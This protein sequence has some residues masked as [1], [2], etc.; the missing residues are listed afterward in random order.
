METE[1]T[2][3]ARWKELLVGRIGENCFHVELSMGTLHVYFPTEKIWDDFAP[4]WAKGKWGTAK[5]AVELWCVKE[6]TPITIDD[7]AWVEFLGPEPKK[8]RLS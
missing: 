3:N 1:I 6:N 8:F 4:P 5:E 7:K 2:Y